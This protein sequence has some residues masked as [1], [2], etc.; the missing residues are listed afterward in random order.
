MK[1]SFFCLVCVILIFATHGYGATSWVVQDQ[2]HRR[3]T[4]GLPVE[5]AVFFE[6]Y[7]VIPALHMWDRVV[8]ISRHAYTNDLLR[9]AMPQIRERIPSAGSGLDVNMEVLLRQRPA[10]VVTWTPRRDL[11]RF[12]EGKGLKVWSLY[13]ERVEDMT[14]I[15]TTFGHLFNRERESTRTVNAMATLFGLVGGRSHA[16]ATGERKRVLWLGVRPTSC[17]G[18]RGIP[19]QLIGL[20]GA[21]NA[22]E[23][24]TGHYAEIPIEKIVSWNPDVIFIWGYAPYGVDAIL[25]DRRWQSI[26]AV[27]DRQVYRTP[28]WSLWSPRLALFGLWMAMKIYPE[29]YPD[30]DFTALQ[31]AFYAQ[32]FGIGTG[33]R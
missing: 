33:K 5:R 11:V 28:T 22:A 6:T 23:E 26:S 4:I 31:R 24:V 30:V 27:K 9:E 25:G 12:M 29:R 32:V 7:E 16:I 3:V 15:V 21:I 10:L 20:V 1:K 17:A 13:P 19:G 8:G 14:E 18:Q 2:F